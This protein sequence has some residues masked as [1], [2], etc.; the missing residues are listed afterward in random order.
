MS[1][2][3]M[4]RDRWD[5]LVRGENCPMCRELAADEQV[6]QHGFTVARLQMSVLRLAANQY[7]P[8]YCVLLCTRHAREPYELSIGERG[9]YLE[10]MMQVGLALEKVYQPIKMNFQILGNAL[11]H[12]HCHII[13]RYYGDDAPGM[14]LNA[15]QHQKRLSPEQYAGQIAAIRAALE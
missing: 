13:P 4:P 9:Q 12:L 7:A 6:N 1:S 5:A 3:W 11:P 2:E 14:P 8:G 10:D 15:M